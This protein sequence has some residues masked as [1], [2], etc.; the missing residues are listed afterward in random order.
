MLTL[1]AYWTARLAWADRLSA[2]PRLE[3]RRRA[4]LLAPLDASLYS[5][6]AD[7]LEMTGGDALPSLRTAVALDPDNPQWRMSLGQQA[8]LAGD[9]ELAER[10]LLAAARLSRQYQPKYLLAGYYFRRGNAD[11]C[12]R[13]S[14]AALAI[15]PDD[16]VPVLNLLGQ[17]LD[18]QPMAAEALR[19][20]PAVARQFLIFLARRKETGAAVSLA[21]HLAQTG[22]AADLPV[23]LGYTG[24]LLAQGDGSD[25]VELWNSLCQRHLMPYEALDGTAGRSLTN[26]NFQHSPSGNGFD[27]HVEGAPGVTAVR[28]DGA[29]RATFSGNEA[30]DCVVAWEYLPLEPGGQYR[31]RQTVQAEDAVSS[32]G[33]RWHL[34]Y[35]K[36]GP[37]WAPL[38]A[39]L[40]DGFRA[41]AGV[42]RLALIYRRAPGSTRLTGEVD[43]TGLRLDRMP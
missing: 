14:N 28:F 36:N 10:S 16:V 11:L 37:V 4:V 12:K 32:A 17:L 20:P 19:Q 39:D 35:P 6:L 33:L 29:L 23:L 30:D 40:S 8:E 27:W 25:A 21:R 43:V 13:W 42:A 3:D 24:E 7:E 15:A 5:R 18:P 34:F 22:T 41:P 9:L 38:E 31:L 26:A 1:A 2:S